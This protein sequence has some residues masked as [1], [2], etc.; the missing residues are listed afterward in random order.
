MG[1]SL[2]RFWQAVTS[3]FRGVSN[4]LTYE[5]ED[6][7]LSETFS[8]TIQ[9][10]GALIEHVDALRKHLLRMAVALIIGSI[11]GAIFTQQIINFLAQPIGGISQLQ[12][13]KPTETIGVFMT[14]ALT[15]GFA[16]ALP[17]IAFEV[18]LFMAPGLHA[19]ARRMG[20]VGIPLAFLFFLGGMA[21]ANYVLL[22][23]AL[24]FLENFLGVRTNWTISSFVGFMTSLLF[25]IGLSF[26]FPLVIYVIT[27]MGLIKPRSLAKQW[28]YAIVIIAVAAAA[29]TPTADPLNMTLVMIPLVI[30]YFIS[31]GLSYLASAG[32]RTAA[33]NEAPPSAPAIPPR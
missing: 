16:I 29:I 27:A 19:R 3:P 7:P 2:S 13:I 31:I 21:F 15:V 25:W 26:E 28:R 1:K 32:R 11:I 8:T 20:L 14:V 24:P 17:Y 22:K 6:R 30:L 10:P 9:Q 4:F 5:P 23:S 18:W 33:A 12:A